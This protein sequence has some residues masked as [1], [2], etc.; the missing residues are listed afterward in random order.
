M[1]SALAMRRSY[2]RTESAH[3]S[4]VPPARCHPARCQVNLPQPRGVGIA[5]AAGAIGAI[6]AIVGIDLPRRTSAANERGTVRPGEEVRM[7]HER[8]SSIDKA[9]RLAGEIAR[10]WGNE[11]GDPTLDVWFRGAKDTWGLQPSACWRT[12]VDEYSSFT[13]FV[14]LVRNVTDT[15]NF[16][17]WDYYCLARHHGIPTRLLDWTEGFMQALFFAFDGWDGSTTP[18]V[19]MLRPAV[20]N[21]R[22]IGLDAILCPNELDGSNREP[23]LWLPYLTKRRMKIGKNKYI[24]NKK[25][26]ALFP[27]RS[28]SR[29]IGQLGTFTVHGTDADPLDKMLGHGSRSDEYLARIDFVR[30]TPKRVRRTLHYLGLRQSAI[31]PD[32]DHIAKDIGYMYGWGGS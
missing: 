1:G 7:L 20:V 21:K 22:S 23:D 26:I 10:N 14:Q 17:D 15:A 32:A 3:A 30:I 29:V 18:C 13:T 31:Y 9:I 16:S 28:N 19:W 24:T 27:S 25:P 2:R 12:D 4:T 6:G 11:V 8:C 5:S